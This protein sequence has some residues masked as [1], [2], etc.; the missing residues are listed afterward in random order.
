MRWRDFFT[1]IV[2]AGI[3]ISESP[4]FAQTFHT[5]RCYDGS[6]F[7]LAFFEGDKRAHLQLDGKA[8]TLPKRIS[9]SGPRYA[10]GGISLR[11]TKTGITLKRGKQST[12]CITRSWVGSLLPTR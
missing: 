11:I 2:A 7:V 4:A 12:E 9:L 1:I 10:K 6:E 3:S 8:V 5:Y